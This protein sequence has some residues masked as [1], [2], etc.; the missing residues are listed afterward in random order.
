[1]VLVA[2]G[3]ELGKAYVSIEADTADLEASLSEAEGQVKEFADSAEREANRS[4]K[5]FE[6]IGRSADGS[7]KRARR[8]FS[9]L[10]EE[11][12]A[13]ASRQVGVITGF[14]GIAAAIAGVSIGA[15]RMGRAIR[16]A[17]TNTKAD[18]FR[19]AISGSARAVRDVT[20][21]IQ[22]LQQEQGPVA[23]SFESV[24]RTSRETSEAI[25]EQARQAINSRNAFEKLYDLFTRGSEG[26]SGEA[27]IIM[28]EARRE[29]DSV[30][31]ATR[32]GLRAAVEAS[33]RANDELLESVSQSMQDVL[34]PP[35][36][37][38]VRL[39]AVDED[40]A[41][42]QERLADA[43]ESQKQRFRDAIESLEEFKFQL[44]DLFAAEEAEVQQQKLD[45][46]AKETQQRVQ[47]LRAEAAD[48][49]R[50]SLDPVQQQ[51]S[52]VEDR[53]GELGELLN[54]N[55]AAEIRDAIRELIAANN[56]QLQQLRRE[57]KEQMAQQARDITEGYR[58]VMEEQFNRYGLDQIFQQL[59]IVAQNT[60]PE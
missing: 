41:R 26:F 32:Q 34:M 59:A 15:F 23:Q 19:D 54:D 49:R 53:I 57:S 29:L 21:G 38:E 1:M 6:R 37:L 24:L 14:A 5:G 7:A 12:Q 45:A 39:R 58:R 25:A 22:T 51:V 4:A 36:E 13:T 33:N 16:N 42:L 8:S 31:R 46:V 2:N 17:L 10:S 40:I 30:G 18:E 52:A 11:L 60:R 3:S 35:T 47:Q 28:E 27:S 56:E 44:S 43:S 48:I 50:K 9:E 55:P 20:R